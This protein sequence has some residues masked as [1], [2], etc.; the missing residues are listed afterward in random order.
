VESRP[1]VSREHSSKWRS[2][3][4]RRYSGISGGRSGA[5]CPERDVKR[6]AGAALYVRDLTLGETLRIDVPVPGASGGPGEPH[7][8][9]AASDGS[10]VFF[11]DTSRLTVG[12]TAVGSEADLY[13][14]DLSVVGGQLKCDLRDATPALHPGEAANIQG[15]VIGADENARYVYFTTNG[16]LTPNAV[17]GSCEEGTPEPLDTSCNLYVYDSESGTLHLVAVVSN[18]DSPDWNAGARGSHTGLAGLTA[19]VS[20]NGRYL[21]FMSARSLTGFDNRGARSNALNEEVFQYDR[22]SDELVCVSC[23]ASGERPEGILDT[24]EFP[25]LLVDRSGVWTGRSLAG[26]LPGWS[27]IDLG[28]ATYQPRYLLDSGRMFFN[29]EV[30][31]VPGDNNRKEDVYEYEPDGHGGCHEASG[32]VGL[33]TGGTSGEESALLDASASGDDLFVM[34]AAKLAAGDKDAA[35]DV[36]DAHVCTEAAPCLSPAPIPPEECGSTDACRPAPSP[37]PDQFEVPATA[38]LS[39]GGNI[40]PMPQAHHSKPQTR[41]KKLA[42]ALRKC[43]R[44]RGHRRHTCEAHARKLYGAVRS[45]TRTSN[46]GGRR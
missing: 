39:T 3:E 10:R 11:K 24:G 14:C 8:E 41:A 26:S 30:G 38:M 2:C 46:H 5:D 34:T 22:V 36:Y 13:V 40:T 20:P 21:A 28:H 35:L 42:A 16:A 18:L 45:R 17:H 6:W 23:A 27:H 33:M 19:R 12:A 15:Q 4:Q 7:F 25:G 32:C 1:A 31:L 29:S 43:K 9:L 44:L 37:Q